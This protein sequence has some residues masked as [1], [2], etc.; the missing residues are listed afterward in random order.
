MTTPNTTTPAAPATAAPRQFS[1]IA[2]PPAGTPAAAAAAPATTPVAT[3]TQ[4]DAGAS[5]Q[6]DVAEAEQGH[7][8][9]M[10]VEI[11]YDAALAHSSD[12]LYKGTIYEAKPTKGGNGIWVGIR[13]QDGSNAS[14]NFMMFRGVKINGQPTLDPNTGKPRMEKD[15]QGQ[16]AWA[17]FCAALGLVP[18]DVTRAVVAYAKAE[19]AEKAPIVG[20]TLMWDFVTKGQFVNGKLNPDATAAMIAAGQTGGE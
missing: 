15:L 3:A 16:K 18:S 14:V 20:L 11:D 13:H 5:D 12:G 9:D 6:Q 4:V 1:R 10:L 8:A 19:T 17:E 2:R 7:A